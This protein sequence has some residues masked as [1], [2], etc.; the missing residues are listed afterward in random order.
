MLVDDIYTTGA[1]IEGCTKVLLA[2]GVNKVYYTSVAI[3]R[4]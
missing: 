3:G 1:T 2:A 4:V